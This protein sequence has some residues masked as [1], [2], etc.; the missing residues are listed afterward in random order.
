MSLL[1]LTCNRTA[2]EQG[3][4]IEN[5]HMALQR[6]QEGSMVLHLTLNFRSK[7]GPGAGLAWKAK[8]IQRVS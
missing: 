2:A 5:K 6:F 3:E 8:D 7:T 4:R 1:C